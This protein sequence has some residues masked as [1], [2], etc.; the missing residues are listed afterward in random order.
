MEVVAA[1][2]LFATVLRRVGDRLTMDTALASA[3]VE[4]GVPTCSVWDLWTLVL[5]QA[6]CG[7]PRRVQRR[8]KA[9]AATLRQHDDDEVHQCRRCAVPW[10]TLVSRRAADTRPSG[11]VW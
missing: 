10:A 11:A 5:A 4:A 9:L 2:R 8:K 1:E 3:L 6:E 7:K